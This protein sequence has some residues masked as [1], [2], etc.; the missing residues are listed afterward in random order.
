MKKSTLIS[1]AKYS[2]AALILL[3][4]VL[5]DT[6]KLG[7][8]GKTLSRE[9]PLI[10]IS[11]L[12][13]FVVLNIGIVRWM[14]LLRAQSIRIS[15]GDAAR[16]TFIGHFWNLAVP[17]AVG[18]DVFKAY[19]V[20]NSFPDLKHE[21]L[22]TVVI[23]RIVGLF[24]LFVL[25]SIAV[26]S[27]WPRLADIPSMKILA[28]FVLGIL[29]AA[30]LGSTL[31]LSHWVRK[32]FKVESILVKL[33][34]GAHLARIGEAIHVYRDHLPTLI[35]TVL[36]SIFCHS[37]L[38]VM[39]ILCTYATV[40]D[41]STTLSTFFVVGPLGLFANAVPLTPG[42]LGV[43]ETAFQEL[44]STATR[45]EITDGG[46]IFLLW[47]VCAYVWMIPGLYFY[48]RGR[49]QIQQTLKEQAQDTETPA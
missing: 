9:W 19:Y 10:L 11:T 12:I 48:L 38:V 36:V 5:S 6:L 25:A 49:G 4:M 14:L 37:S 23:D 31:F 16:L 47:R 30:L 2:V 46:N 7:L 27:F 17:G 22:T 24:G 20:A 34:L 44:M 43:G 33:P 3:Y 32:F 21:A 29:A 15:F 39:I 45:D 8:L 35:G 26:L 42:G 40:P 13:F 18:G 28:C 1:I 41:V